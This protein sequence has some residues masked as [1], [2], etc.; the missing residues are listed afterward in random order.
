MAS[1]KEVEESESCMRRFHLS[2]VKTRE[3]CSTEELHVANQVLIL[4]NY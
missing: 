4:L 3:H 2:S 1:T